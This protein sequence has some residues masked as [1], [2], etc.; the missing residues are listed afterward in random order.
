VFPAVK[1]RFRINEK[2][3][4]GRKNLSLRENMMDILNGPGFLGTHAPF[5]SDLSLLLILVSIVLFT[6]GWQLRLRGRP[7]AHCP[8][9][10]A[11]VLVNLLAAAS[12]M[13]PSYI[14]HILP[15][16]PAK[17][18]KGDYGIT[19]L[20]ALIGAAA[21]LLGVFVVLRAYNLVP[22]KLRFKNYKLFMRTSY[23]LYIAAAMLGVVV[24][25]LVYVAGI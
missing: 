14:A 11:A 8:I 3:I 12:V 18:G 2:S 22:A 19:T 15:G 20:H 16:I 1:F 25:I 21:T 13:I 7:D 6:T 24:Y 17:L 9:Q 5:L 4:H 10:A 23:L